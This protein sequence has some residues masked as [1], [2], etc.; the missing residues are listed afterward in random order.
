VG[1][2]DRHSDNDLF[3]T[4]WRTCVD[5]LMTQ[6][7]QAT[8]AQSNQSIASPLSNGQVTKPVGRHPLASFCNDGMTLE[9]LDLIAKKLDNRWGLNE[10][11]QSVEEVQKQKAFLRSIDDVHRRVSHLL[12]GRFPRD[13]IRLSVYGSC[14]SNLSLGHNSDV[15]MS[16]YLHSIDYVQQ[17]FETGVS[18]ASQYD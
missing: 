11:T 12:Q 8:F 7:C 18:T 5:R 13:K 17:A 14:L 9:Q 4:Q 15:D 3:K 2:G 16:L 1:L 10:E 6:I